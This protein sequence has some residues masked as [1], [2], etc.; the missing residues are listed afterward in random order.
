MFTLKV[1]AD[2]RHLRDSWYTGIQDISVPWYFDYKPDKELGDA[3]DQALAQKPHHVPEPTGKWH[4]AALNDEPAVW[5]SPLAQ[6][7]VVEAWRITPDQVI[8]GLTHFIIPRGTGYLLGPDGKTIDR[9][10]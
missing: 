5:E 2:D 8:T 7:C 10:G 1:A 3:I 9:V 6:A 4:V